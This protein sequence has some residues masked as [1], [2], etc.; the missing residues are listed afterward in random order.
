MKAFSPGR[1]F[2]LFKYMVYLLLAWNVCLWFQ[3]EFVA[4]A[5]LYGVQVGWANV[6]EVYSATI[7]TLA[8][9]ILLLAFELETAVIP[10]EKLK[11]GLKWLL[12]GLSLVC[13]FFIAWS[14][15]PGHC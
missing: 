4:A 5:E 11:G 12:G 3:R 13:Y 6:V 1:L 9:V 10:D 2:Q 8:W 7:D 15:N 14:A